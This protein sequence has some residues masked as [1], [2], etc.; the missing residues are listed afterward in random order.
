MRVVGA[1]LWAV[2]F[3]VAVV[4][5]VVVVVVHRVIVVASV[6]VPMCWWERHQ[7]L[8]QQLPYMKTLSFVVVLSGVSL[9]RFS[10]CAASVIAASV[11]CSHVVGSSTPHIRMM[12]GGTQGI[13]A[14]WPYVISC[15]LL[16]FSTASV[17]AALVD[18]CCYRQ[19]CFYHRLCHIVRKMLKMG[20]FP[21][22]IRRPWHCDGPEGY[23]VGVSWHFMPL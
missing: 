11:S 18:V 1:A 10:L 16:L 8:W 4:V 12:V 7:V 3:I 17:V 14:R 2:G 22:L 19:R 5:V 15:L 21:A 23:N 13:M 9:S 6:G 20:R